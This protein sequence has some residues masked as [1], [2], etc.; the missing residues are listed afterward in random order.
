MIAPFGSSWGVVGLVRPSRKCLLLGDF[1]LF[2][3][4]RNF[5]TSQVDVFFLKKDL[6]RNQ[7]NVDPDNIRAIFRRLPFLLYEVAHVFQQGPFII[8]SFFVKC[9]CFS[10]TFRDLH[11][12]SANACVASVGFQSLPSAREVPSRFS[13]WNWG[14]ILMILPSR[15]EIGKRWKRPPLGIFDEQLTFVVVCRFFFF[16]GG[17]GRIFF[18]VFFSR[19]W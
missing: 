14:W 15:D 5:C 13:A 11:S 3:S 9:V 8:R 10:P 17:G 18:C 1:F 19:N 16:F 2:R 7:T 4:R 6:P 12:L